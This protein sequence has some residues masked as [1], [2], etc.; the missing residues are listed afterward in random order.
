MS[1]TEI[2]VLIAFLTILT[3][4]IAYLIFL[5]IYF[6]SKKFKDIKNSIE[7]YTN[8]CNE[9]NKYIERKKYAFLRIKQT[10]Y[11]KAT[12]ED[13]SLW[14]YKRPML[15]KW[16]NSKYIYNCSRTVCSNASNQP[17]KHLCKYFNIPINEASLSMFENVL[18]NFMTVENGKSL[19]IKE[20]ERIL[21]SIS[22][23]IPF[24][25]KMLN[26][27]LLI[28]KLGFDEID[29]STLYFPT[30]R[31]QYIS[32]GGNASL[33]CEI[34]LNTNQLNNFIKFLSDEIESKKSFSYQRSLMTKKLREFIKNRDKCTCKNCGNSTIKEPN[35]LLE[36]DHI[37][38]LSKGGK[39]TIENLQTLCW[40]CNRTKGNKII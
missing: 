30:F 13:E 25:I 10:N 19:L 24:L 20:R 11:G 2:F 22:N 9:L 4:I 17:F 1:P 31:F 38:P 37:I 16:V 6:R 18:N 26:K 8:N 14:N 7:T 21:N 35:L 33:A 28:E 23:E 40:K 29:L 34:E 27:P 5:F 3:V 36:I 32:S 15:K 39:T 12:Y